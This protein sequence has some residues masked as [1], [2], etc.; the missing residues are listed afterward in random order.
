MAVRVMAVVR[1]VMDV[2]GMGMSM[3]M[4]VMLIVRA[5]IEFHPFNLRFFLAP[6]VQVAARELQFLQLLFE[7]VKI[8]PQI[9]H[10]AEEHV[11]A[12]AA[13]DVEVDRFHFRSPAASALIWLAA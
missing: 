12:D 4:M 6:G 10:R 13:E 1:V 3:P 2:V 8:D 7:G 9:D 11:S 5:Y